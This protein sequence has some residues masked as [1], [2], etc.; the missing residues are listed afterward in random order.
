MWIFIHNSLWK[1]LFS[2]ENIYFP[3]LFPLK[4]IWQTYIGIWFCMEQYEFLP[5]QGRSV[6]LKKETWGL[7]NLCD[8]GPNGFGGFIVV[9]IK[10]DNG[11]EVFT[12]PLRWMCNYTRVSNSIVIS[13]WNKK[14]RMSRLSGW[15]ELTWLVCS[16]KVSWTFF[17]I[18]LTF[19]PGLYIFQG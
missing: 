1:Y 6:L 10:T 4:S 18:L 3:M 19:S 9:S 8:H 11:K 13:M 2:I 15:T 14:I 7:N 17:S 16:L 5:R 12:T